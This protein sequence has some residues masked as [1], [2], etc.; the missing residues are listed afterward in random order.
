MINVNETSIEVQNRDKFYSIYFLSSVCRNTICY[1]YCKYTGEQR[2]DSGLQVIKMGNHEVQCL[3]YIITALI[4]VTNSQARSILKSPI[5]QGGQY[6]GWKG[7]AVPHLEPGI[8][9]YTK[10]D[11]D[12][13]ELVVE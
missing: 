5:C 8:T 6:V 9:S 12:M 1:M 3:T 2:C 11:K 13:D 10:G 7:A 4:K